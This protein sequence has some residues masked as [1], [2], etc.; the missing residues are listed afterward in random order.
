MAKAIGIRPQVYHDIADS[1]GFIGRNSPGAADRFMSAYDATF[2]LISQAP[3]VGEVVPSASPRL[4]GMQVFRV[5]GFPHVALYIERDNSIE[6]L[7][8]VHGA[9]DLEKIIPEIS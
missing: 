9:R 1:A 6:I 5:Q 2:Q 8:V 4:S 3:H 7:R